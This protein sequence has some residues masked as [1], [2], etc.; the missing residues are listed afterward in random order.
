MAKEIPRVHLKGMGKVGNTLREHFIL[1]KEPNAIEDYKQWQICVCGAYIFSKRLSCIKEQSEMKATIKLLTAAGFAGLSLAACGS[2]KST[3]VSVTS[4]STGSGSTTTVPAN[5]SVGFNAAKTEFVL[6]HNLG[7]LPGS[8]L[9]LAKADPT[10]AKGLA[11]AQ[12]WMQFK[13]EIGSGMKGPLIQ[14]KAV[15]LWFY[16]GS[17]SYAAAGVKSYAVAEN[18][19]ILPFT[20]NVLQSTSVQ[21]NDTALNTLSIPKSSSTSGPQLVGAST[22]EIQAAPVGT[23]S[24]NGS[25]LPAICMPTPEAYVAGGK[26]VTAGGMPIITAGPSTIFAGKDITSSTPLPAGTVP[27][28]YDKGT[29][30]CA[31]F[32]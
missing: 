8:E 12:D 16:E 21:I 24:V 32:H 20:S 15:T 29:T 7:L 30:S 3:A 1:S 4:N 26:V 14:A 31:S 28:V 6:P 27:V 17:G 22:L 23:L 10:Y 2:S 25:G 19:E 5:A 13:T 18:T 9:A 11:N